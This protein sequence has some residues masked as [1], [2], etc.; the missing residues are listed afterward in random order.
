MKNINPLQAAAVLF[1]ILLFI[2]FK[3]STVKGHLQDEKDLYQETLKLTTKL[4]GLT[5]TY[6]D[7]NGVLRSIKTILRQ[8]SLKSAK[9]SQKVSNSGI[10]IS[11]SSM[12]KKALNSIMSKILNGS[13][14]VQS[15]KIKRLSGQRVNFAME[16]KW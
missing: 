13:Y 4:S 6:A 14:N 12:D 11:S 8:N 5:E 7:K 1:V 16:I 2:L 9:I 3:L 10:V 15:L